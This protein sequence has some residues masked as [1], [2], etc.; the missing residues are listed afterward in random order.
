MKARLIHILLVRIRIHE[1]FASFAV[2]PT[3]RDNGK[4]STF[5]RAQGVWL[6]ADGLKRRADVVEGKVSTCA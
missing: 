2:Y 1:L 5:Q 3:V 6:Q 4:L